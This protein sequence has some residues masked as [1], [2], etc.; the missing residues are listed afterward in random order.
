M[1]GSAWWKSTR[2]VLA[3][4]KGGVAQV[5][6]GGPGEL[7]VGQLA[8]VGHPGQA[9]V[10]GLG[11]DRGVERARQLGRARLRAAGVGELLDEA[12][13]AVDLDQQIGELHPR[14][15]L[16]GALDERARVLLGGRSDPV[17]LAL[18]PIL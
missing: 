16:D 2:Q 15:A 1:S 6:L 11:E 8:G 14:E 10:G 18:E 9:E 17:A 7:F 12:R 3:A 4:R 13:P 5:P